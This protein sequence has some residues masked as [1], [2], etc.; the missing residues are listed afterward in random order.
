METTCSSRR[1]CSL[2]PRRI[3]TFLFH[4]HYTPVVDHS[5][6]I[7]TENDI[8]DHQKEQDLLCCAVKLIQQAINLKTHGVALDELTEIVLNVDDSQRW[9]YYF[10]DHTHRL[11]F[12]LEPRSMKDIH[13]DL[14]GITKYSHIRML[15]APLLSSADSHLGYIVEAHYWYVPPVSLSG[16]SVPVGFYSGSDPTEV[17]RI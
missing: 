16:M 3:S 15:D 13:I 12:W 1:S 2:L 17:Y 7:F 11:L 4:V 5:K 9:H 10:V 8:S 14:P 6:R